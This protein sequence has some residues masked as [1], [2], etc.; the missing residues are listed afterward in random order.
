LSGARFAF[1]VHPLTELQRRLAAART[2]RVRLL[3]GLNDGRDPG[4]VA[5]LCRLGLRAG[6]AT[7][8]GVVVSVPLLPEQILEDQALALERMLRAVDVAGGGLCAI[9]LGSVLAIAAGRGAAL[10]ER[11]WQP[12]TTGGAATAWAA[13]TNARS[14]AQALGSWPDGPIALLGYA[15][16][17][18]SAV[19]RLLRDQGASRLCVEATGAQARRALSEGLL[20]LPTAAEAVRGAAVVIGASTTGGILDPSALDPG[21]VLVDVALPPT[22]SRPGNAVVLSGEALA[23]PPGYHRDGWGQLYHLLAGY[24]PSHLFACVVEPLVMALSGRR[25]PFAQ[26]RRIAPEAVCEFGRLASELGFR[27][28]LAR[29]WR[30]V[31]AAGL[32]KMVEGRRASPRFGGRP[33]GTTP[34][35]IPRPG[36]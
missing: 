3:A 21:A 17:V 23:L 28:V 15:G 19:A 35:P 6:P 25:E 10:Q 36:D 24:G 2:G 18:G 12:V 13:A 9:G 5:L 34:T 11:V 27:P 1:L 33:T 16:T 30:E 26:G 22:L 14:A 20:V 8:E 31:D 29:R 32:Q 4:D 7:V